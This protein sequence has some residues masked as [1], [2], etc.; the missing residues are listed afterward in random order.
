M[1]H[2]KALPLLIG[3]VQCDVD[4]GAHCRLYNMVAAQRDIEGKQ[5]LCI[6]AFFKVPEQ[7]NDVSPCRNI[8]TQAHEVDPFQKII[9]DWV[10]AIYMDKSAHTQ[11]CRN[12]QCFWSTINVSFC[13]ATMWP[14][15]QYPEWSSKDHIPDGFDW[16]VILQL[17]TLDWLEIRPFSGGGSQ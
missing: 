10:E 12:E 7:I 17:T 11:F 1:Y 16:L 13:T 15:Q 2:S 4:N 5:R 6:S 3:C 8:P 9:Y 14:A